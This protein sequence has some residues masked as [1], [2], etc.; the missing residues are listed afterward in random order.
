MI[1]PINGM[2]LVEPVTQEISECGIVLPATAKTDKYAL[3]N[4]IAVADDVE[5][6][7]LR[8]QLSET[9]KVLVDA[10]DV[11]HERLVDYDGKKVCLVLASE[12][13]AIIDD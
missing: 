10:Y 13:R 9:E 4:L 8:E 2:V 1:Y 5:P 7:K 11:N 6:V 12:I 3:C